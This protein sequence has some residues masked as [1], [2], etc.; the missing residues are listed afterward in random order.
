MHIMNIHRE[1]GTQSHEFVKGWLAYEQQLR[2]VS[3]PRLV[4]RDL[5][6]DVSMTDEQKEQLLKLKEEAEELVQSMYAAPESENESEMSDLEREIAE[7]ADKLG[8]KGKHL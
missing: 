7:L 6:E 1:H 8:D 4:G 2:D 3:D 5:D